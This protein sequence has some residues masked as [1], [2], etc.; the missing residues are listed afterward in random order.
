MY[1]FTGLII[2]KFGGLQEPTM[3]LFE[4]VDTD[5]TFKLDADVEI[6]FDFFNDMDYEEYDHILFTNNNNDSGNF[7]VKTNLLKDVNGFNEYILRGY[8]DHDL[9]N[10][11]KYKNVNI[12]IHTVFNL[13]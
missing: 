3:R 10:R 6:D 13:K 7:L 4:L 1:L 11:I 9:L 2:K 12:N 8:N 5:F